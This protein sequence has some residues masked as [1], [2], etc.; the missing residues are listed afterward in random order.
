LEKLHVL[1][2]RRGVSV[3]IAALGAALATE[4]ITAAPAGLAASIAGT[5]LAGSTATGALSTTLLKTMAMTKLKS[6]LITAVVIG[7]L[8][9]SLVLKR[10]ASATQRAGD[11][12][13]RQQA[14][15]LA[16][17]TADNDR[18]AKLLAQAKSPAANEA[19]VGKLRIETASLRQEIG[20][21]PELR[22]EN[23]RLRALSA[24]SKTPLQSREESMAKGAFVKN[25]MLAFMLYSNEHDG[26][27]P[28]NLEAAAWFL[29]DEAKAETNVTTAQ[30]EVVYHGTREGLGKPDETIVLRE[31]QPWIGPGGKWMKVYGFGNGAAQLHIAADGDFDTFEKQHL[32]RMASPGQ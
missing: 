29:Q 6:G 32:P 11:E 16:H 7:G 14:E 21:L 8:A 10:Q 18:L 1:L 3:P 17:L 28:T 13:L 23:R 26:W 30:F 4:T 9:T 24:Q 19:E 15:Q 25:W 2:V 5:V 20:S 31:K 12:S 27:F 22:Q